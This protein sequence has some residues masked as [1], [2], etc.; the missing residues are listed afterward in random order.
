MHKINILYKHSGQSRLARSLLA[1]FPWNKW[2]K[3]I[4]S[5]LILLTAVCLSLLE[6]ILQPRDSFNYRQT[7]SIKLK[8]GDLHNFQ[9]FCYL[10]LVNKLEFGVSRIY[11]S[12]FV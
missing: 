6:N 2:R 3:M 9:Y 8:N 12:L 11:C 1:R 5:L 7:F 4:N 10:K